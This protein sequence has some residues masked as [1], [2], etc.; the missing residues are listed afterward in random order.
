MGVELGLNHHL[1]LQVVE[2]HDNFIAEM[3]LL[4]RCSVDKFRL[5]EV[6]QQKDERTVIPVT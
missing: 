6:V 2:V 1:L 3:E 5:D 4:A